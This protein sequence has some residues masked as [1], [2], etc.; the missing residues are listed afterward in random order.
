MPRPGAW[1]VEE[2]T[3]GRSMH[4]MS[5]MHITTPGLTGARKDAGFHST[6]M[7]TVRICVMVD[8]VTSMRPQGQ[9]ELG[10]HQ[11]SRRYAPP[12]L[13]PGK[14]SGGPVVLKRQ[15]VRSFLSS[16]LPRRFRTHVQ[17]RWSRISAPKSPGVTSRR[18]A[19][20]MHQHPP[21]AKERR[22]LQVNGVEG[23][24]P[25]C[26]ASRVSHVSIVGGVVSQ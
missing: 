23:M 4:V 14:G 18:L 7:G 5:V 24:G 9:G 25:N 15:G 17:T 21:S 1:G 3:V 12:S 19:Q 2:P 16:R 22:M 10:G 11:V 13:N 8:D 26:H 6:W 20:T